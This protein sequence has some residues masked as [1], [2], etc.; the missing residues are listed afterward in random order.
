[1]ASIGPNVAILWPEVIGVALDPDIVNLQVVGESI[2]PASAPPLLVT[3]SEFIRAA[4][5][6]DVARLVVIFED[7]VGPSGLGRA[8]ARHRPGGRSPYAF[9]V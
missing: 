8:N 3:A 1:L 6:N 2:E 4:A 9:Q 7:G 5:A